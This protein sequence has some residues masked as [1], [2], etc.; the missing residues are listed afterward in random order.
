MDAVLPSKGVI[1]ARCLTPVRWLLAKGVRPV[2]DS[3][4]WVNVAP[5][6]LDALAQL[7]EFSG[8]EPFILAYIDAFKANEEKLT[9]I[10]R[11]LGQSPLVLKR[12][13]A[14]MVNPTKP[15]LNILLANSQVRT[16]AVLATQLLEKVVGEARKWALSQLVSSASLSPEVLVVVIEK[17]RPAPVEFYNTIFESNRTK[18]RAEHLSAMM[19]GLPREFSE[20]PSPMLLTLVQSILNHQQVNADVYD[21]VVDYAL[22]KDVRLMDEFWNIFLAIYPWAVLKNTTLQR[23]VLNLPDGL[24]SVL[25]Q[26]DQ[27]RR[28]QDDIVI[29][30]LNSA[31]PALYQKLLTNKLL[32]LEPKHFISF[33]STGVDAQL[34]Q[35]VL[36]QIAAYTSANPAVLQMIISVMVEPAVE[37]LKVLLA[38]PKFTTNSELVL[39]CLEKVGA[40][41]R[42]I[43]ITDLVERSELDASLLSVIIQYYRKYTPHDLNILRLIVERHAAKLTAAHLERMLSHLKNDGLP[44]H[45]QTDAAQILNRIMK[46]P[47]GSEVVLGVVSY[48][49][50][51]EKKYQEGFWIDGISRLRWDTLS[52]SQLTHL[53]LELSKPI[54]DH[55]L[56]SKVYGEHKAI[57]VDKLINGLN[58]DVYRM[59]LTHD[60]VALSSSQLLQMITR[61]DVAQVQ[62]LLPLIVNQPTADLDIFKKVI[63]VMTEP[64]DEL[65]GLL[66]ENELFTSSDAL[67]TPLLDKLKPATRRRFV[68]ELSNLSKSQ[69]ESDVLNVVIKEGKEEG[70]EEVRRFTELMDKHDSNLLAYHFR[71]MLK[72]LSTPGAVRYPDR[73]LNEL[74]CRMVSSNHAT[75]LVQQEAV[76]MALKFDKDR[77]RNNFLFS[78]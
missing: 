38:N 34:L 54:V 43:I 51:F 68:A 42:Q 70:K 12:V 58:V 7:P 3:S 44:I 72:R 36:P 57:I 9:N 56:Q 39:Q 66:L 64:A 40:D 22:N 18:L 23:M 62:I 17:S 59:L 50:L 28:H 14:V 48:A 11:A 67:I 25:L 5:E 71:T 21:A 2:I 45:F 31:N 47:A 46:H 61:L 1:F 55:L 29:K 19:K 53:F 63:E 26:T 60:H 73:A 30:L 65:L 33:L 13:I 15:F 74:L 16:D 24:M 76:L 78:E 4:V 37:L 41:T 27:F 77:E 8:N 6:T 10:V 75:R 20:A 35:P 52:A 32:K 49:L 69:M